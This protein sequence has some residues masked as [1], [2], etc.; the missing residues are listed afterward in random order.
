MEAHPLL[1]ASRAEQ[2]YRRHQQPFPAPPS[3]GY[4]SPPLSHPNSPEEPGMIPHASY[5]FSDVGG[6]GG[7]GGGG[8]GGGIGMGDAR[9]FSP[10]SPPEL[11]TTRKR[12]AAAI[13]MHE[14]E[15]LDPVF[16]Y[17]AMEK[18]RKRESGGPAW[19]SVGVEHDS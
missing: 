11:D 13:V 2:E 5:S 4:P 10:L 16:G 14:G 8:G 17:Q 3:R 7:G 9:Q 6:V 18:E 15:D 12:I 19:I 1:S